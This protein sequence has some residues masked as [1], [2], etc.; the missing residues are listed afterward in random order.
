MKTKAVR[1]HGVRDFRLEEFELSP[2]KED[3]ILAEVICDG[4]CMSTYKMAQLG[5]KHKRVPAGIA[6]NPTIIGHEFCGVI[7]KVGD[8]WKDQYKPGEHFVMQPNIDK[9]IYATIGYTYTEIGGDATYVKIMNKAME[10]GCLL[11]FKGETYIEGAVVEPLGCVVGGFNAMHHYKDTSSYELVP[12]I[13]E[14]GSLA[15]MGATG[16]MG[17]L[18][19]DLAIHGDRKPAR[20]LVAGR[21]KAKLER[22]KKL[23]T[24]EDAAA[25]GVELIYMDTEGRN[26]FGKEFRKLAKGGS[27]F[28]DAFVFA[29]D[30]DLVTQTQAMMGFDGC[31]N[32]FAGPIDPNFMSTI[33][34]YDVHYNA[35]HVVANSGGNNEDTLQ[36]VELIESKKVNVAKIATHILGLDQAGQATLDL[37]NIGGG[38]KIV[39]T[40]KRYPLTDIASIHEKDDPFHRGLSEILAANN[41]VWCKEAEDYFLQNAPEL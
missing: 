22:A 8:K 7:L 37:P 19:I 11:K 36:A 38:K 26:D 15:L 5:E 25:N 1:I 16:P 17:F 29:A 39:Y 35:L 32:F 33:N 40:H 23:Y 27:G 10:D 3:E 12:G 21:N 31:L 6:Q 28:D 14:G 2:M 13:R 34:F 20:V 18:A 30:A 41:D 9:D 24:V 4:I